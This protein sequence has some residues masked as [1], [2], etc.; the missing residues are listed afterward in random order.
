MELITM[1]LTKKEAQLIT[2]LRKVD[3]ANPIGVDGVTTDFFLNAM[4][5]AAKG[6][7][8]EAERR[9]LLFQEQRKRGGIIDLREVQRFKLHSDDPRK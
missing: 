4:I 3:S 6:A 8:S 2:G 1:E 9:Y 7:V 5:A